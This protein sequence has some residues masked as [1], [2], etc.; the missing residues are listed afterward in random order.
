MNSLGNDARLLL[1]VE[2]GIVMTISTM[3]HH[4]PTRYHSISFNR[5]DYRNH[6]NRGGTHVCSH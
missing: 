2:D 6:C 5:L 1:E 4:L 3:P